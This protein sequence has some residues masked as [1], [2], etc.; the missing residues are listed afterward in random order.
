[1]LRPYIEA[2]TVKGFIATFVTQ[3]SAAAMHGI[4]RR[5]V[6]SVRLET[7]VSQTS[8]LI[9]IYTYTTFC[10]GSLSSSASFELVTAKGWLKTSA[11]NQYF[12]FIMWKGS[13]A[14][15]MEIES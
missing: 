6:D 4:S 11:K 3:F 7:Q 1:M 8:N 5:L 2:N 12:V 10:C 15:K 13:G 14:N 9:Y